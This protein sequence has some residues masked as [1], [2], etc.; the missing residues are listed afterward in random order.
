MVKQSLWLKLGGLLLV[1]L[2]VA[3]P[4]W[5]VVTA[6]RGFHLLALGSA[7]LFL[8]WRRLDPNPVTAEVG[9]LYTVFFSMGYGFFFVAT[10]LLFDPGTTDL[11]ILMGCWLLVVV[12]GNRLS[13][14]GH[15]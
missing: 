10:F 14:I 5:L 8:A 9:K 2:L 4:L 11:L 1:Y 15:P 13:V 12:I 7:L 6:V 3:V